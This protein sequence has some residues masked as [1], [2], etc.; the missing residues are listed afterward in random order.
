[1][2][3]VCPKAVFN[4]A[5][6]KKINLLQNVCKIQTFLLYTI[7]RLFNNKDY[8]NGNDNRSFRYSYI[9]WCN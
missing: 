8:N 1:M 5:F 4:T 2:K 3:F 6:V 7:V 9:C